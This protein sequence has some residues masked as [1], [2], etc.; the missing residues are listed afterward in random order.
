MRIKNVDKLQAEFIEKIDGLIITGGG[1]DVPPEY[2]NAKAHPKTRLKMRRSEFEKDLTLHF[3]KTKKPI[4]GICGGM[5]LLAALYGGEL[6]QYLPEEGCYKEHTQDTP[7]DQ[8]WHSVKIVK[9]TILSSIFDIKDD[10][11][12][13][14]SVHQ[15]AVKNPG[16]MTVSAIA[17]DGLIEAIEDS[18]HPFCVGVQWHPE[19]FVSEYDH[20]LFDAFIK[21]AVKT[22]N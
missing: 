13:V 10:F 21:I 6:F 12:P 18:S 1:L 9:D 15:Q 3:L 5:Q 4:F 19:C 11:I 14:N 8:S 7:R 20:K 22:I 2:Y 17:D 16:K